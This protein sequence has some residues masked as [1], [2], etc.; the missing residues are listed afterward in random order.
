MSFGRKMRAATSGNKR[1]AER[2]KTFASAIVE[3][4]ASRHNVTI[5]DIS[6]YG[7]RISG[8]MP[9][10]ARRELRIR[11]NEI[12]LFGT[13]AWR[14][15]NSLGIKFEEVLSDHNST[16]ICRAVVSAEAYSRQFDREAS[17]HALA[18][19]PGGA[20]AVKALADTN[21]ASASSPAN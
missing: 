7:A 10:V 18:N 12:D 9:S 13:V 8:V 15:D 1:K 16:D 4:P 6:Q 17:L 2:S 3:T 14:K 20:P 5:V 11:V 21:A 19:S